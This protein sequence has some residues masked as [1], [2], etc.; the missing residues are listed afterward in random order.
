MKHISLVNYIRFAR[1]MERV[2]QARIPQ[3]VQSQLELQLR[4]TKLDSFSEPTVDSDDL[5]NGDVTRNLDDS[6]VP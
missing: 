1:F 2:I 3:T 5:A 6:G 4:R